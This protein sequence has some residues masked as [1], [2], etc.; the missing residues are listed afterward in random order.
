MLIKIADYYLT[1]GTFTYDAH[2][3][4]VYLHEGTS[5]TLKDDNAKE[6]QSILDEAIAA[7]KTVSQIVTEQRAQ[8]EQLNKRAE[9]LNAQIAQVTA[10]ENELKQQAAMLDAAQK[11]MKSPMVIPPGFGR[12]RR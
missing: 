10:Y 8:D 1:V 11:Q 4:T 12:K 3:Q 6:L 7:Q 9:Q 2:L 5:L